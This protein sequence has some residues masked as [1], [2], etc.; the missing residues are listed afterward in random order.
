MIIFQDVIENTDLTREELEANIPED[1]DPISTTDVK[2]RD[3]IVR[4]FIHKGETI[5]KC[6]RFRWRR[7]WTGNRINI[8]VWGFRHRLWSCRDRLVWIKQC[9][10]WNK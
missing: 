5:S 9:F 4:Y 7:D 3:F 6:N 1:L 2:I 10:M 8:F